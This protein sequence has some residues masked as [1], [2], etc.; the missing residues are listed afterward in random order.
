MYLRIRLSPLGF[1][2]YPNHLDLIWLLFVYYPWVLSSFQNGGILISNILSKI[3]GISTEECKTACFFLETSPGTYHLNN[4]FHLKSHF[5]SPETFNEVNEFCWLLR[6]GISN[7]VENY[8]KFD[9]TTNLCKKEK[10]ALHTLVTEKN[11]VHVV[12]DT[13]K[14]LGPASADKSDVINEV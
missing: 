5:V 6:D 9:F 1:I 14:N 13:D 10:R 12:N 7:L 8:V 11:R 2:T 4:K 3:S